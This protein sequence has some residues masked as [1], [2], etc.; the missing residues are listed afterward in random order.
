MYS[1]GRLPVRHPHV[2]I[3][4]PTIGHRHATSGAASSTR[5]ST[6]TATTPADGTIVNWN[7]KPAAGWEA[8]DDSWGY[9]SVH[10]NNL[11][12]RTR[13]PA[14]DAHAGVTG[15]RDEQGR[16]AG[17][18]VGE[19]DPRRAVGARD[20]PRAERARRSGWSSCSQDWRAQGSHRLDLDN[21]GTIDHPGAAIL[22]KAW[23][24][25]ADAVMGPVLGPQLGDLACAHEP[26]QPR[27]QPGLVLQRRAGTATSTRTCARSLGRPVAGRFKTRFC[28]ERRP[29]DV[30]RLA[31]RGARPG[32][33]SSSRTS[34][35]NPNPD[36]WRVDAAAE[37]I[38]F[39]P[40]FLGPR[41]AGP[42]GPRSSRRSATRATA[43]AGIREARERPGSQC[44]GRF[45]APWTSC[46][47]RAIPATT[48]STSCGSKRTPR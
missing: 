2:D 35:G 44:P 12:E 47:P 34:S 13:R 37:R 42:T 38:F 32:G 45:A 17:P 19:G 11:L 22:D 18:A 6:R 29:G 33:A 20:R 41:C 31:V 21:N 30:P 36:D 25:I 40:G 10:R 24:K 28:G 27:Q 16:H 26:R 7:N 43:R 4:L 14:S 5:T 23:P 3:G 15:R 1:S 46:V 39:S 48:T 8:A 9:G